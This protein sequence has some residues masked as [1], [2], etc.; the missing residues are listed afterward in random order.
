MGGQRISQLHMRCIVADR[1]VDPDELFNPRNRGNLDVTAAASRHLR[2]YALF[3]HAQYIDIELL[4]DFIGIQRVSLLVD[5][6]IQLPTHALSYE[7][8]V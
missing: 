4:Q 8:I 5:F 7:H 2:I 6:V 1:L 3:V